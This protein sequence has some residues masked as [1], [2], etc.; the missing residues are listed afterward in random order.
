MTTSAPFSPTFSNFILPNAGRIHQYVE[1]DSQPKEASWV[2]KRAG[3]TLTFPI[4]LT[5]TRPEMDLVITD[6]QFSDTKSE[7]W[8]RSKLLGYGSDACVRLEGDSEF[9][10]IKLAHPKPEHRL[11]IQDEFR[12]MRKLSHLSFVAK[13]SSEPLTDEEGI[14]GFRLELLDKV[15]DEEATARKE[16]I[17]TLLAELH[18]AGY[19]HGDLQFRNVMKRKD[20][21]LVLIDFG[22][23]GA[24]GEA[25][26]GHVPR[27]MNRSRVYRAQPDLD[28]VE[29]FM[30]P[31]NVR[32]HQ[33]VGMSREAWMASQPAPAIICD[34]QGLSNV[35]RQCG[36]N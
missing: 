4:D 33:E 15:E 6:L 24:L 31:Y 19:C 26:P 18:R 23:A 25:V 20:G 2:Y 17:L 13:I 34:S 5:K 14:L 29:R 21:D 35:K 1:I 12:V 16:E 8:R 28:H 3:S 7:L 10:I 11:R 30:G 36:S 32:N 9:P 22:Y 27:Y